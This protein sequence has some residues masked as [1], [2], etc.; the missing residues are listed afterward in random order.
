MMCLP[1]GEVAVSKNARTLPPI[2]LEERATR[3]RDLSAAIKAA[4]QSGR[5]GRPLSEEE[6][7][8][9]DKDLAELKRRYWQWRKIEQGLDEKGR[10]RKELLPTTTQV[11]ARLKQLETATNDIQTVLLKMDAY[12]SSLLIDSIDEDCKFLENPIWHQKDTEES[13]SQFSISPITELEEIEYDV[14][15]WAISFDDNR[16]RISRE[17]AHKA[18]LQNF[19]IWLDGIRVAKQRLEFLNRFV[20][21]NIFKQIN[22]GSNGQLVHACHSILKKY[23]ISKMIILRDGLTAL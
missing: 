2:A 1:L 22:G 13:K 6:N 10:V 12:T 5:D 17:L 14:S 16:N 3:Q 19:N 21:G 18:L 4:I 9:L 20:T 23:M 11:A 8:E 7:Q 15:H